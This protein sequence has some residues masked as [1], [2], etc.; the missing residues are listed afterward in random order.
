MY[1]NNKYFLVSFITVTIFLLTSFSE[2]HA[3]V[4]GSYDLHGWAWSSNVGWISLNSSDTGSGGGPYKVQMLSGGDLSGYAWSSNLGWISFNTND[5]VG[6]PSVTAGNIDVNTG[7]ITGS[8]RVVS[9]IG[10]NDGWNGCLELSGVNHLSPDQS[11]NMGVT[12]NNSNGSIGGYAWGSDVIGWVQ[13]MG[14]CDSN[15]GYQFISPTISVTSSATVTMGTYPTLSWTLN[16]FGPYDTCR[17]DGSPDNSIF[18]RI[19]DRDWSATTSSSGQSNLPVTNQSVYVY[20]VT[21]YSHD[22]KATLSASTTVTGIAPAQ[23]TVSLTPNDAAYCSTSGSGT[24]NQGATVN[25]IAIPKSG[26]KFDSWTQGGTVISTSANFIL[27]ASDT[28]TLIANCSLIRVPVIGPRNE[29]L[30]PI[31][32]VL[33]YIGN[34]P[35]D[36]LINGWKR[37]TGPVGIPFAVVWSVPD[38]FKKGDCSPDLAYPSGPTPDWS[39]STSTINSAIVNGLG[40]SMSISLSAI[41]AKAGTY[42]FSLSCT[43]SSSVTR[44]ATPVTLRLN[45]STTGEI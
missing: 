38:I 42:K 3:Q 27:I 23:V 25:A 31:D 16:N 35:T 32:N 2:A 14:T 44:I 39:W 15:C 1:K 20:T 8:I 34:S 22:L 26:Y 43:N 10:R 9:G 17:G 36:A 41:G 19:G 30:P 13:F 40:G 12:Y 45:T 5:L 18:P 7:A 24:Y 28:T 33:L 21:C 29:P 11:G 37:L 6:C 4:S